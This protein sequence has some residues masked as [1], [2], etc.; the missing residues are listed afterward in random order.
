MDDE[1]A[2]PDGIDAE[3]VPMMLPGS[4]TCHLVFSR[5]CRRRLGRDAQEK[6]HQP[7]SPCNIPFA[8]NI[9]FFVVSQKDS[10]QVHDP[11]ESANGISMSRFFSN[12]S[13]CLLCR[14]ALG[15]RGG[16]A[17]SV[18][19]GRRVRIWR[20]GALGPRGTACAESGFVGKLYF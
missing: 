2:D 14:G 9:C 7:T 1:E 17:P 13:S 16:G 5:G 4:A 12:K 10:Q 11:A 19:V 18:P 20:R 6:F 3:S 8:T 15:P